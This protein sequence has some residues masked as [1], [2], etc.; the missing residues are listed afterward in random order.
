M[1][2]VLRARARASKRS[3]SEQ[4]KYYAHLGMMGKENPDLPMSFIEGILEG[5]EESRTG[6]AEPYQWG[7]IG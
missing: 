7:R 5:L 3:L 1:V 4:I 2:R 6:L